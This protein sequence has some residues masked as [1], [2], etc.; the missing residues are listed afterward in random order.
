VSQDPVFWDI[1]LTK[2][3]NSLL[4]NPQFQNSYSYSGN[5]P[6]IRSDASGRCVDGV[7]TLVCISAY[8]MLSSIVGGLALSVYG[9][10]TN[11]PDLIQAGMALTEA[12]T[13]GGTPIAVSNGQPNYYTGSTK[14]P[15]PR[16]LVD[17]NNNEGSMQGTL[18]SGHTISEHVEVNQLY[19]N[20]RL[21]ANPRMKGVSYFDSKKSADAI[22][23]KMLEEHSG[24]IQKNL[25]NPNLKIG[26]T[27]GNKYDSSFSKSTGT[28]IS[29]STRQPERVNSST[30]VL[31]KTGQSSFKVLT[32]YPSVGV[33]KK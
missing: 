32:A 20:Q 30:L 26:Q 4:T 9:G 21:D 1:G 22:V 25:A 31:V 5:N 7:S 17:L 12:G 15:T 23:T 13:A 2:E 16:A 8:G 3:G 27:I 10:T 14:N 11:N 28:Y 33:T 6:I 24:A 19:A 18:R 29:Q